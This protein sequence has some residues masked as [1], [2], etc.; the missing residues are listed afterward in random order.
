MKIKNIRLGYIIIALNNAFFWYAPWLLFVYRYIDIQQAT[1]LQLVGMV[2]RIISEVPTGAFSDLVG[3]KRTLLLALLLTAIG[4]TSM[5]F[6]SNFTQFILVYIMISLGQSFY[7]GTMDAFMYDSLVEKRQEDR[8]PSV[9]S[10]SNTFLNISTAIATISGGFL[11]QIWGGLPFLLTGIAKFIGFFITFF[12]DEPKVDTTVF[13]FK[14]FIIQT[15]KGF[16]S[17]FSKKFVKLSLI[18]LLLGS[19]ST[20]AYEI[21]DDVAVVDWGYNAMG[22]SILYTVLILISIPSGII[23]EYVARKI[24]LKYLIVIGIFTLSINYI[25]S[26]WINAY[27]WT[28]LFLLRVIYAPIKKAAIMDSLNQNTNSSDRATTISTYELLSRLPFALLGIPIGSIM[29]NNG[30]KL[31]SVGFSSLLLVLLFIGFIV[32]SLR[33]TK[34]ATT[35]LQ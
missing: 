9:L 15:G 33:S 8:Y 2:T 12:I 17:L 30:V 19:F 6:S 20:V 34:R 23:Y 31:F 16:A 32:Y 5:A 4:E 7:S 29:K 21:L 3:K 11:F 1:V 14:N 35:L 26:L 22:I 25:F 18:I 10:R 13:S 27:M 24:K 28:F